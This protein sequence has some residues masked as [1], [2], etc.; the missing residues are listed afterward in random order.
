MHIQ[1]LPIQVSEQLFLM[2]CMI[3]WLFLPKL[4]S[5]L[6]FFLFPHYATTNWNQL[7]NIYA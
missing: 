1:V 2:E 7:Y 3:F 4:F 6:F 5:G